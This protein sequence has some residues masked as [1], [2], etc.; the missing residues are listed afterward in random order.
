[1]SIRKTLGN[2]ILTCFFLAQQL[3]RKNVLYFKILLIF[4]KCYTCPKIYVHKLFL[5]NTTRRPTKQDI[6]T[7]FKSIICT[8]YF[9]QVIKTTTEK[10]VANLRKFRN[11]CTVKD[12]I[13][14]TCEA[15]DQSEIYQ[16]ILCK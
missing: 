7:T 16:T 9:S 13:N 8:G 6:F 5:T 14:N 12:D 10:Y 3:L 1:M 15:R 2:K 4:G 11:S